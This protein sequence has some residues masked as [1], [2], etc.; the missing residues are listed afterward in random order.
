MTTNS[1]EIVDAIQTVITDPGIMDSFTQ[2]LYFGATVV[3]VLLIFTMIR[4]MVDNGH[5]EM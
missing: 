4:S 1:Q 5:E 3:A 2:G